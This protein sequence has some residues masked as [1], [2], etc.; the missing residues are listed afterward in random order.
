MQG[1]INKCNEKLDNTSIVYIGDGNPE[2]DS[3]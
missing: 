3:E 2:D 1:I